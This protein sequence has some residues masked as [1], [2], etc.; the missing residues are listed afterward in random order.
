MTA[1]YFKNVKTGKRY[2]VVRLDK[3]KNLVVLRG[4]NAEFTEKFDKARFKKMG[5]VL[6]QGE[7]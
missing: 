2:K 6:E 4:E 3:D 5:Y 1:L 7:D